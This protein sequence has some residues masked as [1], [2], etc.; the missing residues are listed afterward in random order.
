MCCGGDDERSE[1]TVRFRWKCD[2]ATARMRERD[3]TIDMR[4]LFCSLASLNLVKL[5]AKRSHSKRTLLD[6]RKSDDRPNSNRIHLVDNDDSFCSCATRFFQTKYT[7]CQ[8]MIA[9]SLLQISHRRTIS[10]STKHRSFEGHTS[11]LS[12]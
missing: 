8:L 10:N 5:T 6:R 4:F 3:T 9:C 7:C 12:N 2:L 11:T 1:E